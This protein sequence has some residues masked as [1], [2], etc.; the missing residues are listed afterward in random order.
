M[1]GQKKCKPAAPPAKGLH[2]AAPHA[3]PEAPASLPRHKREG[4]GVPTGTS[5]AGWGF[6]TGRASG[7]HV[8]K[9]PTLAARYGHGGP[10]S[11]PS[12]ATLGVPWA[13]A[14]AS[15]SGPAAVGEGTTTSPRPGGHPGGRPP[16]AYPATRGGA[17]PHPLEQK[18]QTLRES[19]A[20][21]ARRRGRGHHD[22]PA[23]EAPPRGATPRWTTPPPETR[24]GRDRHRGSANAF[25][26]DPMRWSPK[27]RSPTTPMRATRGRGSAPPP[28]PTWRG[29][30]P[31]HV[32]GGATAPPATKHPTPPHHPTQKKTGGKR[33]TQRG[34]GGYVA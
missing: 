4:R 16:V 21:M 19:H 17:N 34:W 1:T 23:R 15:Q 8:R 27:R 22:R 13:L 18:G 33:K 24:G 32:K 29:R 31:V 20:L 3:A 11:S 5:P 28:T 7:S 25:G 9:A 6:Q 30:R 2:G 12:P 26:Y 10:T 14:T